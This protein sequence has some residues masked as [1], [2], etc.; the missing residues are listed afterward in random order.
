MVASLFTW[1]A[2]KHET[3]EEAGYELVPGPGD[4]NL[5][6]TLSK[7]DFVPEMAGPQQLYLNNS[8]NKVYLKGICQ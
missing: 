4:K 5:V 7:I 2:D 3:L 6:L 1:L 8:A